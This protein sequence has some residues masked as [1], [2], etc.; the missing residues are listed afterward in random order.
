[1]SDAETHRHLDDLERRLAHLEA[2][3]RLPYT[4]GTYQPTYLGGTTPGATTYSA[5]SGFYVKIQ[6]FVLAWGVVIWTAA[7]GTGD[8]HVSLPFVSN[9]TAGSYHSGSVRLVNVTF[10][11]H[12]PELF[13]NPNTAY[14]QMDSPLTNA[15]PTTV[16]IE[17]AGNIV[18]SVAYFT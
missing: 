4:S 16:A 18:F 11:N 17:A 15:G 12:A 5:Q 6:R 3:S 9:T 7:T 8:A 10:A 14:F 13:I 1:M 2:V